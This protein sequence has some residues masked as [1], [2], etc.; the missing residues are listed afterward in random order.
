MYE[1]GVYLT[2]VA[3][4]F[5]TVQSYIRDEPTNKSG[6]TGLLEPLQAAMDLLNSVCVEVNKQF[7]EKMCGLAMGVQTGA[8]AYGEVDYQAAGTVTAAGGGS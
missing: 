1:F 2:A 5:S 7:D 4:D 6:F 3:D 8:H